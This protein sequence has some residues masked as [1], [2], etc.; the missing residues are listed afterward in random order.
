MC[1]HCVDDK[2]LSLEISE[3]VLGGQRVPTVIS[4][5]GDKDCDQ[6]LTNKNEWPIR[7]N[8]KTVEEVVCIEYNGIW[9][10]LY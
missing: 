8:V 1:T 6:S 5:M 4:T 9:R 2:D 7:K 3:L 10:V